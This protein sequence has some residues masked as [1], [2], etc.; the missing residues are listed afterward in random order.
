MGD[1]SDD[2]RG[3][4][5]GIVVEYAGHT[6][7]PKWVAPKPFQW[8][9]TRFGK[10]GHASVKL[11]EIIEITIVKQH[12]AVHG[13]N[14]WTLN[15]EAFPMETMKPMYTVHKGRRC[16]L[17]FR[18]ASD[19]IPPLR[20]WG[21][22]PFLHQDRGR[23]VQQRRR[24][25]CIPAGRSG[26]ALAP[27]DGDSIARCRGSRARYARSRLYDGDLHRLSA[28]R[29]RRRARCHR[30][31]FPSVVRLRGREG[32]LDT[33]YSQGSCCGD[34]SRR[35]K[36]RRARAHGRGDLADRPSRARRLGD[37]RLRVVAHAAPAA[38]QGKFGVVDSGGCGNWRP[39]RGT[40]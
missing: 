20:P 40:R 5:L 32:P 35:G 31:Y 2:N 15:G 12:A 23:S 37:G 24:P 4:G 14:T 16:R 36:R 30:R 13:F 17:K 19:D 33:A 9:Y 27:T 10:A 8:D 26:H 39:G 3:R 11:D 18:N 1:L 28:R 38:V 21:A 6:G 25:P 22:F 7:K 29:T 34:I